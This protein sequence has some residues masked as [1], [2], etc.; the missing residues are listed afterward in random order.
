MLMRESVESGETLEQALH[1][2]LMGEFG[3]TGRIEM[4]LGAIVSHFK[5]NEIPLLLEKTTLYFLVTLLT[6]QP[7]KRIKDIENTSNIEWKSGE[8][9]SQEMPLQARR[10]GRSDV[11]E[12]LV[13]ERGVFYRKSQE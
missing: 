6:F 8:F 11:D 3:M 4:F 10:L 9:L 1:R 13:I 7:E 2:G 5:R 12:S